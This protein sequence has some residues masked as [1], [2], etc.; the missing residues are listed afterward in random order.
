MKIT[1]IIKKRCKIILNLRVETVIS[2][3]KKIKNFSIHTEK[4][5]KFK[6]VDKKIY[7]EIDQ[8]LKLVKSGIKI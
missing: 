4:Y 5:L 7:D 1:N 2:N 6:F 3:L 8:I